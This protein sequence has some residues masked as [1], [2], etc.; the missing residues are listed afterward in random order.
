MVRVEACVPAKE[1]NVKSVS[2][3]ALGVV[4]GL[5]LAASPLGA[6]EK[7]AAPVASDAPKYD[8]SKA[9]IAAAGPL[10]KAINAKDFAAAT[11]AF[12]A[13]EAAATKPDEKL[14]LAKFK[15]QVAK[16]QNDNAAANL[17]LQGLLA[18][19][20]LPA[21]ERALVNYQLG[22]EAYSAKDYAKTISY[23]D[24]AA[25]AGFKEP[26]GYIMAADAS[27]KLKKFSEGVALA[28]QGIALQA[29]SGKPVSED[30]YAR[31]Y[32]GALNTK[33][34]DL[35][36]KTGIDLIRHYPTRSNWR[37]VL[38]NY[39]DLHKLDAQLA[40]DLFR[41]MR[42]TKSIDGER[43]Y[44]EYAALAVE[45]GLSGE[46]KAV[47][48]EAFASGKVPPSSRALTEV[49]DLANKNA[50]S[51]LAE[52]PAAVAR[53]QA[54]ASGRPSFA[55]G[56]AYLAYGEDAKA[57]PLYRA[58]LAKKTDV[59]ADAANTRLGI[60]LARSGDKEG[61]RAAFAQVHGTRQYI[62]QFW[63]LY[64]DMGVPGA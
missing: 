28:Q 47:T 56:D 58:A 57:I 38:V 24:A 37:S 52:L 18:A 29:A 51:G 9:F 13:V 25:Q 41:L 23:I 10:Q 20:A 22:A 60:A 55:T 53:A 45:K 7:P 44:Y 39:R 4:L 40:L 19:T 35:S 2:Q 64:L 32:S 33:N 26:D 1:M 46:A 54:A 48:T 59:D 16:A 8:L 42:L 49:R 17:A 61:A 31:T 63:Q 15:Y 5:G 6:R 21:S 50:A 11:A 3:L 34:D 62:A 27:Y 36:V 14:I 43:D 30:F 12:P